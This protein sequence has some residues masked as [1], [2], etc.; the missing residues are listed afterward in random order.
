MPRST[1]LTAQV[2]PEAPAYLRKTPGTHLKLDGCC[3]IRATKHLTTL[4]DQAKMP[5]YIYLIIHHCSAILS[6]PDVDRHSQTSM[7]L[8][9]LDHLDTTLHLT[10]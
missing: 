5:T 8:A 1:V 3:C 10:D 2:L 4:L 7:D 6:A 9:N